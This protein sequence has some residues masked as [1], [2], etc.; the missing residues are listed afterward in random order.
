MRIAFYAP[1]KPPTHEVPSGDRA[2][3][4]A[5]ITALGGTG[6]TIDLAST[7]V[8]RDS[9]GDS[10][11]QTALRAKAQAEIERLVPQGRLAGWQAWISYHNYYKCP[12]LIG[13]TV[14]SALG[15]PY[16]LIEATRA[17]KRLSGPWAA[18]AQAAETA[19]DA[20]DA[21]FYLTHR[22]AEALRT[23]RPPAQRL[24]HLPPFLPQE[25]LPP[26]TRRGGTILSVGMFRQGDK[27]ASYRLIAATLALLHTPGWRLEIAGD[28]PARA[29]VEA[30]MAPFG[31]RVRFLGALEGT[32]VQKAY[33]TASVLF[34]PGVNEAFGMTYLEAQAAGLPVVAQNRPG[35]IDVLAPGAAYP[36]PDAGAAALARRL[37]MLLMLPKLCAHLG[38]NARRYVRQHH[39][40]GTARTIL[41][42]TLDEVLA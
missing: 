36:N 1:M 40:L 39:L 32:D 30:L 23:H 24:I 29:E 20:A 5:L 16:L 37:D 25:V 41:Q 9:T 10:A 11:V 31:D 28:G 3:A 8:T 17:H 21:V 42:T 2:M 38:Q 18:F 13:P 12:D 33:E 14:S 27:F 4:R 26:E 34:W 7:I 22:D 15:V 19:T 35:V 6:F